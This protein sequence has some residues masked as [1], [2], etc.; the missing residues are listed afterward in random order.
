MDYEFLLLVKDA[1][2]LV[3]ALVNL[4]FDLADRLFDLTGLAVRFA[5]CRQV[6][7]PGRR[8]LLSL[9][10][11]SDL[12]FQPFRFASFNFVTKRHCSTGRTGQ[13]DTSGGRSNSTVGPREV[14]RMPGR[15]GMA[16][17][18]GQAPIAVRL[19]ASTAKRSHDSGA[20]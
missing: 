7:V 12:S 14:P 11:S 3:D 18:L 9:S 1:L 20:T 10:P 6:L 8:R 2:H 16:A 17:S 13:A 19:L 15:W 4:L 5:L